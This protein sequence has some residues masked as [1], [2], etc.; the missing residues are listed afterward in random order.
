MTPTDDPL[1]GWRAVLSGC[2]ITA[3]GLV[4]GV[5]I[6]ATLAVLPSVVTR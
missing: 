2:A 3:L 1:G 5:A 4:L 6:V